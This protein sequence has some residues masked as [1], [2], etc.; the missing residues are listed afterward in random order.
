V[1]ISHLPLF[2]GKATSDSRPRSSAD[3]H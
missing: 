3:R 2:L 1:S